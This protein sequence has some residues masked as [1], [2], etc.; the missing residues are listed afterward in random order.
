MTALLAAYPA[1]TRRPLAEW[2]AGVACTALVV[3][4]P[5][6]RMAVAGDWPGVAAWAGGVLFIPSLAF[7]SGTLARTPRLFQ[8]LY[9]PLWYLVL[10]GVAAQRPGR[11]GG[12]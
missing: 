7:L 4:A 1:A 12:P 9:V 6:V 5:A 8:A 11:G 10:N 3:A 2:V